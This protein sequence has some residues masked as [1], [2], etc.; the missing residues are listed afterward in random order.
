MNKLTKTVLIT[1]LALFAVGIICSGAGYALNGKYRDDSSGFHIDINGKEYGRGRDKKSDKKDNSY[2]Y[3][4]DGYGNGG[5]YYGNGAYGSGGSD[6]EDFFR[7]FGMGDDFFDEFFGDGGGYYGGD[8]YND[9]SS[10]GRIY[11]Y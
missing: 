7:S 3:G 10:Y 1:S 8:D 9:N 11:Y 5:G 6:I 2:G 4:G